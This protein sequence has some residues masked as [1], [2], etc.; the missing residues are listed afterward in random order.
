LRF[1]G[2]PLAIEI[3]RARVPHLANAAR[4]LWLASM[5]FSFIVAVG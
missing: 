1:L 5:L 3:L 2:L 4:S